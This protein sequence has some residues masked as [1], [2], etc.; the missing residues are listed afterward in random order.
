MGRK[1]VW[2]N[3]KQKIKETAYIET[4][5]NGMKLIV[6]PKKK[7]KEIYNMGNEVWFDR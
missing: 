7:Q 6:V 1:I 4:F 2:K 3:R 5:E